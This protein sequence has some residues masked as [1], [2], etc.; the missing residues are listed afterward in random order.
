MSMFDIFLL[1]PTGNFNIII[2]DR[3]KLNIALQVALYGLVFSAVSIINSMSRWRHC[4][5]PALVSPRDQ[6]DSAFDPGVELEMNNS[7]VPVSVCLRW[8][9]FFCPSRAIPTLL[10]LNTTVAKHKFITIVLSADT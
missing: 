4:N 1:L 3:V 9:H 8:L 5:F 10:D 7:I 6:S 2:L